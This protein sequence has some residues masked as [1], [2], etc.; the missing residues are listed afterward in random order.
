MTE[1]LSPPGFGPDNTNV[2]IPE[3]SKE[4]HLDPKEASEIPVIPKAP[5]KEEPTVIPGIPA[6]DVDENRIPEAPTSTAQTYREQPN[7]RPEV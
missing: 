7:L 5:K 6:Q 3:E 1:V 2:A 4:K